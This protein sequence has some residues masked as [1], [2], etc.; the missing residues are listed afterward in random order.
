M[1]PHR[2]YILTLASS[3]ACVVFVTACAGTAAPRAS[4][5]SPPTLMTPA[6]LVAVPYPEPDRRL[7]YGADSSQ[8]GELRI[9]RGRGPHPV[10]VL[11]HGGCFKAQYATL[12]D[13]GALAAAL[14][15][16]GI[17]TLER[18][19]PP[20]RPAGRRMA[21]HVSRRRPR[22]RSPPHH[23]RPVRARPRA[24]RRRRSLRRRASRDVDRRARTAPDARASSTSPARSRYAASSTSPVRST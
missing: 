1:T 16:D 9:P 2:H 19:V 10:A 22:R 14:T 12:R 4:S 11:V 8:Y 21:Q 5:A 24:R 15:A 23:R 3:F 20:R 6:S 17:A 7:A 13:L 18:R